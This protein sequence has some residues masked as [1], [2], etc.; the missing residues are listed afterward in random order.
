MQVDRSYLL[1]QFFG[2]FEQKAAKVVAVEAIIGSA[3]FLEAAA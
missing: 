1:D 2:N 3:I